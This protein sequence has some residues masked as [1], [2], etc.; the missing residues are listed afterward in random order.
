MTMKFKNGHSEQTPA[1]LLTPAKCLLVR[2]DSLSAIRN[3]SS[4]EMQQKKIVINANGWSKNTV[5]I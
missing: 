2:K 3:A 1:F 4:L 5:N